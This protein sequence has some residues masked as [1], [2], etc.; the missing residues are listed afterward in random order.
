VF[1]VGQ[2]AYDTSQFIE[3]ARDLTE[4]F[5]NSNYHWDASNSEATVVRAAF[6]ETFDEEMRTPAVL[7]YQAVYIIADAIERSGSANSS[8]IRDALAE[9]DYADHILPYEGAIEFDA[10]GENIV[11]S[12]VLMQIQ[13][14]EVLQV[15]PPEFAESEPRFCTS[16]GR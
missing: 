10:A 13:G 12:P 9:T 7:A 6:E 8:D 4:C 3:D 11:A 16:W 15:W 1:G 2:G 5:F 14:G